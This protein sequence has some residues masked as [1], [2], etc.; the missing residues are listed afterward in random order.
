M[1]HSCNDAFAT[2]YSSCV[3]HG[4]TDAACSDVAN[5]ALVACLTP[6]AEPVVVV[7]VDH[8]PYY[9]HHHHHRHHHIPWWRHTYYDLVY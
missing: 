1:S 2:A 4:G 7:E 3:A 9:H 8:H 6:H 5:Q